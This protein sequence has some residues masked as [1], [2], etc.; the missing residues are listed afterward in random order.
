MGFADLI[1]LFAAVVV[2]GLFI[3]YLVDR[4]TKLR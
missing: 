2:P 1:F 3:L 4:F